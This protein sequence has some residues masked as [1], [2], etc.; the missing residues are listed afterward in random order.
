MDDQSLNILLVLNN[1]VD[2]ILHP[3]LEV[4]GKKTQVLI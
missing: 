3:Q 4:E 1:S 2:N